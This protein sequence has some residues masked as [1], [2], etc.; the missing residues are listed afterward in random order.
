LQDLAANGYRASIESIDYPKKM[1]AGSTGTVVIKLKNEG[2]RT[3]GEKTRLGTSE[4]RDR[5]SAFRAPSWLSEKRVL[6][7]EGNVKSGQKA[8][9]QF[10]IVAPAQAGKHVEHFNLVEEGVAWF[11]DIVPGGGPK[12]DA[13]ALSIEVTPADPNG[14]PPNG[15]GGG[16]GSEPTGGG[17]AGGADP[18]APPAADPGA[19]SSTGSCAMTS[20]P[21]DGSIAAGGFALAAFLAARRRRRR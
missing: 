3:W 19:P 7:I 12:D 4:K 5:K 8:T 2:A 17:G 21:R 13:I 16:G 18:I 11:S 20:A 15:T 14:P 9:L 6:G 1:A 10:N